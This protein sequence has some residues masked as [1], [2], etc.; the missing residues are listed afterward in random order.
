MPTPHPHARHVRRARKYPIHARYNPRTDLPVYVPTYPAPPLPY[1]GGGGQ[2]T[3]GPI[4]LDELTIL[5]GLPS[6]FAYFVDANNI[7]F[8]TDANDNFL[9]GT[10]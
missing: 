10:I 9:I 1:P 3:P 5:D 2:V 4:D 7:Y 6:G 8:L